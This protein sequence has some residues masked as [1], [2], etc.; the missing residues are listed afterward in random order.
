MRLLIDTHILL[1]LNSG[2]ENLTSDQMAVLS[3]PTNEVF[4]SAVTVWEIVVKRAKGLIRFDGRIESMVESQGFQHLP[5][6]A[7][8]AEGIAE[9]P[10]Y[11]R[12]P[13]DRMLIAQS[14]IEQMTL[15]T[16]DAAI[17]KYPVVC[18]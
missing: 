1:W 16:S 8:H 18:L 11:H 13:F 6:S 5:V 15:I 7:A 3:D 9:L 2:Q 17:R 12:D 10:M 14:R 4:V